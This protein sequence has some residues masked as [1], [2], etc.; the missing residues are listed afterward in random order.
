MNPGHV[1]ASRVSALNKLPVA[2]GDYVLYW[3]QQSQ[4]AA[5][6]HALEYAL[7]RANELE[8]PLLVTFG[9]TDGYP[10]ANA[11]HYSFM[12]EGL[13]DVG[14][15]LEKRGIGF[16]LQRGDP[17]DVAL[18]L[19]TGASLIVCDRGYLRPQKEWRKRVV[20]AASCPVIQVEAD[21]VVPVDVASGKRE[22]AARTLRPKV[23]RLWPE[24]LHELTPLTVKKK[25][26][27]VTLDSLEWRNP[28]AVL[29]GL[30][31]DRSVPPVT[32][33]FRGGTVEAEKI[34]R[35]FCSNLLHNYKEG[36]NQPQTNNV[37][38]MSKYLHF[39]QISPVWLALEVR[40]HRQSGA[41][42]IT[43]FIDELLVRRELSMNWV[44]FTDRYGSYESLPDWSRQTLAK[45]AADPRP[46]L[47]SRE[48]LEAA[49]THDPYWNAAMKEMR[50]TGYMHNRMRMYW[51][52]KIVEWTRTPE[53][54]H[55]T[56]L[57]INN[58]YFL[59][60]RDGNSFANI[61]WLFGQHDR[62]WFERPVFGKV[63]YMNAAGLERKCDI[64]AYVRKVNELARRSYEQNSISTSK[65]YAK[66]KSS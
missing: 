5:C 20:D 44:K 16:S 49:A 29:H 10:E 58:K 39:G 48:E 17:A 15:A 1:A 6:N 19:G 24:Y 31:V 2:R 65:P 23:T 45:H 30:V 26:T 25:F 21:V 66:K 38:Q 11:R 27:G 59:D 3:M 37:S 28:E 12:L 22:F 62:P 61:A 36:R 14:M 8:L 52:K 18:K 4:R 50:C 35:H 47:Y 60:G 55:A 13:R 40:K 34:F 41:E 51:G 46:Y 53:E 7:A 63:R 32:Q 56:A 57:A 9:L 33:Y 64:K 43:S 42:N 54:A